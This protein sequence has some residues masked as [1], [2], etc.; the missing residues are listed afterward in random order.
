MVGH[1]RRVSG[2]RNPEGERNLGVLVEVAVVHNQPLRVAYPTKQPALYARLGEDV[3]G[4]DV[5]RNLLLAALIKGR[6][7][8]AAVGHHRRAKAGTLRRLGEDGG[9]GGLVVEDEGKLW[10]DRRVDLGREQFDHIGRAV[11]VGVARAG[12]RRRKPIHD[13]PPV[14]GRHGRDAIE[15]RARTVARNRRAD[16]GEEERAA[17]VGGRRCCGQRGG[18]TTLVEDATE[19]GGVLLDA[20]RGCQVGVFRDAQERGPGGGA[21]EL[22]AGGDDGLIEREPVA[23]GLKH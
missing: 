20:G 9:R 3:G 13:R 12:N 21:G 16:A 4:V 15:Q 8:A 5:D 18:H 17:E 7:E 22:A 2:S 6:L 11:G 10:R 19:V 23:H 14:V 1:R